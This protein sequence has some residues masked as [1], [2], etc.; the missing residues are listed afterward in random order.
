MAL[1]GILIFAFLCLHMGDFWYK[2]KF[3]DTL[4]TVEYAGYDE[5]VQDLYARVDVA[6]QQGVLVLI[7]LAG[8]IALAFHLWH[9]FESAFQTLGLTH[10]RY[11]FL[12]RWIGRGYS[13]VIPLAFAIIPVYMYFNG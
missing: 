9:G 8:L 10:K 5:P 4:R 3:T 11:G 13:I 2:M 1:L 6:Y 7:Y 12:F